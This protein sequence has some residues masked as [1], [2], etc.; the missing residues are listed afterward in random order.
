MDDFQHGLLGQQRNHVCG[1]TYPVLGYPDAGSDNR[2][3]LQ[4]LCQEDR[5]RHRHNHAPGN[6]R[7][8][9]HMGV[10]CDGKN[11]LWPRCVLF[12]KLPKLLFAD[13]SV[14]L[15]AGG[16]GCG[17]RKHGLLGL[18][19]ADQYLSSLAGDWDLL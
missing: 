2:C 3:C 10:L 4:L 9:F 17:L 8:P 1:A 14:L 11:F 7:P 5:Q 12:I 13:K 18:R 15:D 6:L 19:H 16:S